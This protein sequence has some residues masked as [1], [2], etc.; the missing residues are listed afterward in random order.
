MIGW[1]V[2][3]GINHLIACDIRFQPL[4][5]NHGIPVIYDGTVTEIKESEAA[6]IPVNSDSSPFHS[7]LKTI[8][9]QQVNGKAAI[10]IFERLSDALG[11]KTGDLIEPQHVI[12]AVVEVVFIDGKKK[13]NV[14]GR[15][16][17]LSELKAKYILDLALHFD[18]E[19]KLKGIDLNSLSDQDL[20]QKLISVKGLGPW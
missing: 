2:V 17:G 10:L 13:I 6:Y 18:D 19:T 5:Q 16:S 7:L 15:V 1:S 3:D 9:Y 11:I 14:N 4:I 12:N 8:I 20:H